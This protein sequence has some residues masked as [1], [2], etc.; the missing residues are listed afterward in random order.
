VKLFNK[1]KVKQ[2]IQVHILPYILYLLARFIYL[3]NKKR[4]FYPNDDFSSES[5]ILCCWHGNLLMQP[6][7]YHK[8]KKN[9]SLKAIISEHRDGITIQ[10]VMSLLNVGSF[11]GSSTKNGARALIGAIKAIKKG[12]DI[13][14]TPDGPQGPIYSVADG[15][16]VLSQ[17]TRAKILPFQTV[18]S[19]CWQFNSWDRFTIPK[20][21]GTIDFYVGD[22]FDV[23][24]LS[25]DEAKQ[26]IKNNMMLIGDKDV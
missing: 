19:K 12:I 17:K 20:P 13:A 8:F 2:Y 23:D 9:G 15:I 14:I 16:I 6:F 10:K 11:S 22:P 25:I 4:Y 5:F 24:D 21:F 7:N 1:K 18:A 3:T 26:K